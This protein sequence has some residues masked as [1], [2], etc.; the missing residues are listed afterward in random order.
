MSYIYTIKYA[1][2]T[3]LHFFIF[4]HIPQDLPDCHS[5]KNG[6]APILYKRRR[7]TQLDRGC[8]LSILWQSRGCNG[9][10]AAR[11]GGT[12][13]HL[14]LWRR[15]ASHRRVSAFLLVLLHGSFSVC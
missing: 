8:K 13:T 11:R 4:Y 10:K 3:I 5:R 15:R 2:Y 9:T 6:T 12:P 1:I 7:E 14:V